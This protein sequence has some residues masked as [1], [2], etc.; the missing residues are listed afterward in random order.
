MREVTLGKNKFQ[1]TNVT[2]RA[3]LATRRMTKVFRG[4]MRKD[5][6]GYIPVIV[7]FPPT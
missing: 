7:T 4:C 2:R 5:L 1:D 3:L 6:E